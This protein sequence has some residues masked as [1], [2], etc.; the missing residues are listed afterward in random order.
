MAPV[1]GSDS[2]GHHLRATTFVLARGR[3][4]DDIREAVIAGRTCVRDPGACSFE[5]RVEGGPWS[6][7]GSALAA[8]PWVEARARGGS[9]DGRSIEIFL[10]GERVASPSSDEIVRIALPR[11]RCSVVRARVEQGFSAPV[12]VGC[13]L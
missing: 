9:D 13:G 1:G 4:K 12:Y 10:D 11:G 5:V 7:V 8:A 2:H 6:V 3:T